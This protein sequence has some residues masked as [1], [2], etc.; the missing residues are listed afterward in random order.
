VVFIRQSILYLKCGH[1]GKPILGLRR[2]GV[3]Q[4]FDVNGSRLYFLKLVFGLQFVA[5]LISTSVTAAP[6]LKLDMPMRIGIHQQS[7][8]LDR[9]I[10][11]GGESASGFSLLDLILVPGEKREK[12]HLTL[13][14][15]R[16]QKWKGPPGYFHMHLD[17]TGRRLRLSLT[18]VSQIKRGDIMSRIA[19]ASHLLKDLRVLSNPADSVAHLEFN[20]K[21]PVRAKAA[22][23][24]GDDRQ[25]SLEFERRE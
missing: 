8:W 12:W 10:L 17:P 14:D 4:N 22:T 3:L 16:G 19:I 13:G 1:Y 6:G 23:E 7:A 5:L 11:V 25:L 2:I 9:G 24:P 21:Y 15:V 18:Q 20:F